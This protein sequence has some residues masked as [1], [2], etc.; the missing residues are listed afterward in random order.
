LLTELTFILLGLWLER[1]I[2]IVAVNGNVTLMQPIKRESIYLAY[3][4]EHDYIVDTY[5]IKR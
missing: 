3:T 1:N 5:V 4:T 2:R